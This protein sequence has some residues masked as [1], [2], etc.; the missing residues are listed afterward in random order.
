[1]TVQLNV[2]QPSM[3]T[4]LK[5]RDHL[6]PHPPYEDALNPRRVVPTFDKNQQGPLRFPVHGE[7]GK[8]KWSCTADFARLEP[9]SPDFARLQKHYFYT[10]LLGSC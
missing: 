8:R 6:T 2:N 10:R 3:T 1:M 7:W 9:T 4:N 5:W